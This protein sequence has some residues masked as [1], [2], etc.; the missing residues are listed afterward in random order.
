MTFSDT[1]FAFP[2]RPH[3]RGGLPKE[4]REA[5]AKKELIE[6][7]RASNVTPI[8]CPPGSALIAKAERDDEAIKAHIQR[9]LD[10]SAPKQTKSNLEIP[11]LKTKEGYKNSSRL[12]NANSERK[13]ISGK[14]GLAILRFLET[15][16]TPATARE[17][18]T[19]VKAN[20]FTSCCKSELVMLHTIRAFFRRR[21]DVFV[22][23]DKVVKQS[24]YGLR[25]WYRND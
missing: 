10:Q 3:R 15:R 7:A 14:L 11:K 8:K 16:E 13:P 25:S 12:P 19:G 22:K 5:V 4:S 17:V 2:L 21:D 9:A 6:I 23:L 1:N 18:L 24:K 20:G